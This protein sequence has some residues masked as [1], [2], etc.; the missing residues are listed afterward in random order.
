MGVCIIYLF[1]L[2]A[3]PSQASKD[4]VFRFNLEY[5]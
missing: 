1:I 2:L 5:R 4:I 3:L